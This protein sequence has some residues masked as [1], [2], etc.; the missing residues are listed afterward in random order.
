[1]TAVTITS[2]TPYRPAVATG[3]ARPHGRVSRA[4]YLRRRLATAVIAVVVVLV[5]AQAGVA[6][7]SST[8]DRAPERTPAST[9]SVA[10]VTVHQG[11]SLW[12]V[13]QRLA[14]G[15][16]P[17]PIVDALAQ[18]RRGA[19]LLVGETVRWDG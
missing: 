2:R 19:P 8:H 18:A 5:T 10:E 16:D 7:G 14:P 3:W 12:S 13:A 9:S 4:T 1:M 6:L 11:D 17:R 15:E